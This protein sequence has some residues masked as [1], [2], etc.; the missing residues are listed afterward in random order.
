MDRKQGIEMG[1]L[2]EKKSFRRYH[3]PAAVVVVNGIDLVARGS[4][5][6]HLCAALNPFKN[7]FICSNN[8]SPMEKNGKINSTPW[9]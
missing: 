2:E 1:L 4:H 3:Q 6:R 8:C 5:E 9:Y 7:G